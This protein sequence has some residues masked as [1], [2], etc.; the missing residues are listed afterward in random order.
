MKKLLLGGIALSSLL[1]AISASAADLP[2]ASSYKAP[3]LLAPVYS[4]T[5]FYVGANIGYSWGNAH[6]D[7]SGSANSVSLQGSAFQITNPPAPFADSSS[8]RLNGLIGGEQIGLNYQFSPKWVLGFEFDIQGSGERGSRTVVDPFS[9]TVCGGAA[10]GPGGPPFCFFTTTA[11][12][13][14]TTGYDAKIDWFGTARGRV[15]YLINDQVLLYGTG[16]VAYGNVKLLGTTTVSAALVG[17]PPT[18]ALAAF[19]GSKTNAGFAVG[20]G[21]EG[22]FSNG[23]PSGWTWKLEYL[24]VDLGSLDTV[25]LGTS[26]STAPTVLSLSLGT[27]TT[28]TRFIDNIVRVGLNYKLF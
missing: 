24:Y 21:V 26:P 9:A 14:V 13:T 27:V 2:P 16:G 7:L 6:T 11:T 5:G 25:A 4:W 10:A 22:R 3:P 28:H 19:S 8:R 1:T 17:I 12:G 23:L 15:G 20:G 18:S